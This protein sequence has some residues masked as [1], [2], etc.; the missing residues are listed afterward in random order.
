[1][2]KLNWNPSHD[3][4][5]DIYYHLNLKL[6]LHTHAQDGFFPLYIASQKGFNVIVKMLLWAGATVDMQDEVG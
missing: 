4:Y 1:M 6:P 2:C 3:V 5:I